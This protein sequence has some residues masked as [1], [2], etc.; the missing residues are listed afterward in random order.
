MGFGLADKS[1]SQEP[2]LELLDAL[3][4]LK[5]WLYRETAR[6]LMALKAYAKVP[7]LEYE[8]HIPEKSLLYKTTFLGLP[9]FNTDLA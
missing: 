3:T 8:R 2:D 4:R 9:Y 7:K 1:C 5:A 6:A